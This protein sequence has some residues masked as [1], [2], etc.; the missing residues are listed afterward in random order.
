[1]RNSLLF[2]M[3]HASDSRMH[4]CLGTLSSQNH[5]LSWHTHDTFGGF[6]FYLFLFP[7]SSFFLFP[8]THCLFKLFIYCSV[9]QLYIL[10]TNQCPRCSCANLRPFGYATPLMTSSSGGVWTGAQPLFPV[11]VPRLRSRRVWGTLNDIW[12]WRFEQWHTYIT[13]VW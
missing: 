11:G 12:T 4:G 10:R 5:D 9:H 7:P 13:V 2:T 6:S 1:M 8:V 3:V